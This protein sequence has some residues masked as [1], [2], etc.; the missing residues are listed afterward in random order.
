MIRRDFANVGVTIHRVDRGIDTGEILRQVTIELEPRSD[1][2][3]TLEAKQAVAGA[4]ALAEWIARN[5]PPFAGCP[6]AAPPSGE[7]RFYNSPG[8]RDYRR[9]QKILKSI[10]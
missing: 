10:C 1:N 9:F 4:N 5:E 3:I 6:P 7:S 8:L 2:L